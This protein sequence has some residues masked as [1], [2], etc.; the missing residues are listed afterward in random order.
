[1]WFL[2]DFWSF[3]GWDL[4]KYVYLCDFCM[5]FDHFM[6]GIWTNTFYVWFVYD[7]W[8]FYGRDLDKKSVRRGVLTGPCRHKEVPRAIVPLYRAG[9]FEIGPG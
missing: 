3:Y 6:D 8:S 1:M 2:Y 9:I 4:D 5:T 7:F